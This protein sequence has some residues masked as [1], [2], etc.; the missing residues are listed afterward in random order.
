MKTAV[1][2]LICGDWGLAGT[3]KLCAASQVRALE[4]RT[5]IHDWSKIGL[6]EENYLKTYDEIRNAGM[7]V[8]SLATGVVARGYDP[9]ALKELAEC[10]KLAVLWHCRGLRIM[11]GNFKARRSQSVPAID[12]DGLVRWLRDRRR[13]FSPLAAD[14]SLLQQMLA[15]RK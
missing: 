9:D 5:G 6:P 7:E 14:L 15:Q 10:A 4:V 1:S 11:L 8:C 3:L 13:G 12:R 2:T